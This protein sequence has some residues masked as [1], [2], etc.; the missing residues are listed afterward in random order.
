VAQRRD[1]LILKEEKK[2][3]AAEARKALADLSA[4]P[5]E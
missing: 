4:E 2:R 1:E 3:G 5:A